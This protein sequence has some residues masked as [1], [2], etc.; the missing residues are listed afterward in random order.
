MTS[1][2]PEI[3]WL[4]ILRRTWKEAGDDDV[5]GRSA[6]LSYY[7]FLALFPGLICVLNLIQAIA[8]SSD[9][10]RTELMQFLSNALPPSAADLIQK[11]L[12]EV[13]HSG[14]A[15][16]ISFSIIFSIWTA[17]AG[18]SAI[19]D[20]L[21]AEHEVTESRGFIRKNLTAIGLTAVCAVLLLSAL[22]IVLGGGSTVAE[23]SSGMGKLALKIVQWPLALALVLL[24]LALIY[25]FA[26]DVKD[27]KWHWITPG[28][29]AALS[30]WLIASFGL[31]IYLHFFNS[32]DATYGSLGAVIIL[33]L[34]FYLTGAAV[35][36]GAEINSV[37]E[38]AAAEQGDP[39]AKAKGQ[40]VPE[41]P[42][43]RAAHA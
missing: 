14:R 11:T 5:L 23:L 22:T 15:S 25:F 39:E 12:T 31:K 8:G 40:K 24:M 10:I 20:T 19:M 41:Q 18:M 35:L 1:E 34:W 32:Y 9:S 6:Q 29:A 17:S 21:N 43:T 4:Q 38:D 42:K 16:K 27:Q 30:L 2:V 13:S 26:P 37:L 7:F 33:L 36:F 28:A 3:S